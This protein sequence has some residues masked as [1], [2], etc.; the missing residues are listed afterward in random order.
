MK[1]LFNFKLYLEG[2][3]KIKLIGIAAAIVTVGLSAIIPI[4]KRSVRNWSS[5]MR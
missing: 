3:K 4:M 2:L 1:E 5:R